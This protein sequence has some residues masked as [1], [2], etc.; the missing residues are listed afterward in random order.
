MT[1]QFSRNITCKKCEGNIEKAVEQEE[2]LCEEVEPVHEFTY[3]GDR[4]NASGGCEVAVTARTRCGWVKLR[5]CD[6]LLYGRRF[7][8][9][10]KEAVYRS[11]VRPAKLYGSEAWRLKENQTG[12]LQ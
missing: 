12:N 6:E 11:Y 2:K 3:L 10:L 5:E 9:K 7:P 4:V 1:P 8:L